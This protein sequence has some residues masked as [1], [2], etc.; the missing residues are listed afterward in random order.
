[1]WYANPVTKIYFAMKRY[2]YNQQFRYISELK[3][4]GEKNPQ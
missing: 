4:V 2:E 1:M 3:E